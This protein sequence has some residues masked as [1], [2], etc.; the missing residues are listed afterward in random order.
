MTN[1]VNNV[2]CGGRWPPKEK[3]PPRTRS[4][5]E[6]PEEP[7][8]SCM[9]RRPTPPSRDGRA[10]PPPVHVGVRSTRG[11]AASAPPVA[12]ATATKEDPG[13]RQDPDSSLNG[14]PR[15][16]PPNASP[17]APSPG[18]RPFDQT[19]ALQRGDDEDAGQVSRCQKLI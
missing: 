18:H 5:G 19:C 1:T 14:A 10:R 3:E 12:H 8:R 13:R 17:G 16:A 15:R 7:A 9:T 11:S 6:I 4:S 2:G